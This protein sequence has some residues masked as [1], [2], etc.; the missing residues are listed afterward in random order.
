[1]FVLNIANPQLLNNAVYP[2]SLIKL[3]KAA[4]WRRIF[5]PSKLATLKCAITTLTGG[6]QNSAKTVESVSDV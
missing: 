1:M 4:F 3:A 2:R 6:S 5:T